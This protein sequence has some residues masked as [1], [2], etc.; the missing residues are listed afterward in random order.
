MQTDLQPT[1]ERQIHHLINY[2]QGTVHI[3]QRDISCARTSKAGIEKGFHLKDIGVVLHA[4]FHQDFG[5]LDKV[6]VGTEDQKADAD[7]L[8]QDGPCR[9][10]RC[11]TSRRKKMTDEDEDG[12]TPAPWCWPRL[13]PPSGT[14]GMGLCG[15]YNWS[16]IVQSLSI[17]PTGLNQPIEKQSASIR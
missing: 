7:A 5:I 3:G 16:G 15:A 6:Q 1:L 13:Q 12:P 4:K 2:I 11:A 17:N 14:G 10:T 8:Q 9:N